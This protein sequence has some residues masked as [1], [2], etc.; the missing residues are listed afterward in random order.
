M[1]AES[2]FLDWM[3]S[4]SPIDFQPAEPSERVTTG[5]SDES[6]PL[7]HRFRVVG[8]TPS[9]VVQLLKPGEDAVQFASIQ[10]DPATPIAG[11]H[12]DANPLPLL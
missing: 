1:G 5:V 2:A 8:V 11:V 9:G 3:S 12:G 6:A 4:R 7:D 10:P